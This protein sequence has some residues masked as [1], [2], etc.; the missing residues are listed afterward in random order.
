MLTVGAIFA[1]RYPAVQ[2]YVTKKAAAYLSKQL[3]TEIR[4]EKVYLKP[5]R[6]LQIEG[7]SINDRAGKKILDAKNVTATFSLAKLFQREI[8]IRKLA[9]EDTYVNYELYT[10]STNISF[11]IDY[12]TPP[13]DT[14]SSS[15][16]SIRFNLKQVVLKNNQFKLVDHR[17]ESHQEGLNFNDLDLYAIS[18]EFD[19]ITISDKEVKVNISKLTFQ[20]K[21]GLHLRELSAKSYVS[22]TR[23]EFQDLHLRTNRSKVG[24]YLQFSYRSFADFEDFIDKVEMKGQLLDAF[25]DSRDIQYF[26]PEMERVKFIT[27]ISKA[28]VSGRVANLHAHNVSLRTG[29]HTQ[30]SG[31]LSMRGLPDIQ[32]TTFDFDLASLRTSAKDLEELVPALANLHHFSLP[33]QLHKL[34]EISYKGSFKGFYYNFNIH[35]NAATALGE[36]ATTSNVVIS[37]SLR[38]SGLLNSKSFELGK[39]LNSQAI[40]QTAFD[41]KY[42]GKGINL[43]SL[44]LAAEGQISNLSFKDYRYARA[45]FSGNIENRLLSVSGSIDDP[46]AMLSLQGNIDWNQTL[47]IYTLSSTIETL[48][49]KRLNVFSKD[50]IVVKQ[51]NLQATLQGS[52]LNSLNGH[53]Y[54][55]EI[56]FQ[57]SR[58]TFAMNYLDFTSEGDELSKL[59]ILKS[60]VV[61]GQLSG[62]IDLN[63]IGSY[64]R[65]LAMR[66]APAINIEAS[67]YN[68]QN[69][70]LQ[71]NIKSFDPISAL[72]D[73]NLQ[74]EDGAHLTAKF[75][76]DDY[77]ANFKAFSPTVSYRGMKIN[78]LSLTERADDRAFSL[79]VDADRFSF[80]DSAYVE[81][82]HIQNTLANDSLTFQIALSESSRANY[83]NLNGNIHF[84]YNKPAY[85]RFDKSE[86]VLDKEKWQINEDADLRVSKGKF[87]LKNLL[88]KRDRQEVSLN[89]VLSNEDDDLE[90]AF[91]DFSLSSL[92]GITK[93]LG[94]QLQGNLNGDVHVHSVFQKPT[95]STHIS[96]TPI[97]FNNLPIGT[98]QVNADFDP[99]HGLVQL[100]SKLVD[101]DGRG[102]DLT[103]T[104]DVQSSTDALQL[105]GKVKDLDLGILQPFVRTLVSDLYG[106]V[107]G[108]VNIRGTLRNPI[109]NG[110][111]DIRDA[112][113]LVNYLNTTYVLSN[114]QSLIQDNRIHLNNL[115]FSDARNSKASAKGFIDLSTL[116]DPTLDIEATAD[117]FQIL[118]TGRKDN[119]MFFGTAY[120]SGIFRFKGPTSGIN[121]DINARSNPNTVVTIPFNSSLKVS[122]NDFFYFTNTDS[123]A[124][125]TALSKR[126]FQGLTMNMDLNLTRDAEINLENNIGSLKGVGTGNISLRI[127]NL[128]DFEMFGDYHVLAGKFHFTAQ[129]FF[130]KFFDLKEGGT[131]RW[132]G[133]PAEATI[134]LS[135]SYQ[136]RTSVAP[137]YNAAGRTENNDRILAQADMILKGTLSQPEVS[138][139]LNFPQDP[140]VKDELQ[141][142]LS[143]GNNINQ[144]AISLIVRRSFT[145]ASTQEFGREVNNTL[146]S[147]GTEIAF[148]QLNSIIS[149]SL[150]MNFLD[151]NI[152]SFNDASASL[153]FF[154]DRLILTGGVSDRSRSQLT[155]L[156]LFSD[157]VAT[158]AEVTFRL[159]QDGNLVLRAYNRLN[160]RNF[161]FTPYSDYISAVGLV[162]RQEFN[163]LS[164]FWRKLWIWNERKLRATPTAAVD[165]LSNN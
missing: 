136:Q 79:L 156:T 47:P 163:S 93:P 127:S 2:T 103:G 30:L 15:P 48:D 85:I 38:Y 82:I 118:N 51:S 80:T 83:L 58:G 27:A 87:Y 61:D 131:I 76:S 146:L 43:A 140:Y 77:T 31:D 37:P 4:I 100:H 40:R 22:T 113:F 63:T 90:I 24:N 159:R 162:Y 67:P 130:N 91:R 111:A 56:Q 78:N 45:N 110:A 60:D 33:E 26:A 115:R 70:D 84:A 41:I 97:I 34:G 107:S 71:V 116:T 64:F 132:A 161:L 75:S 151:L 92:S 125:D 105:Q 86:I 142:Y 104:Y 19:D 59:L 139:D 28:E 134:N 160:T 145:P 68:P 158:D 62:Q 5:F 6:S 106:K 8:E 152:R 12:L 112:S 89:G 14:T 66:Y 29:T 65:S 148:N 96:T 9:L 73:P 165:S 102:V 10:D 23:M 147:A 69:F 36:L 17:R 133:N 25:V 164:E 1:L 141:G 16:A 98:L 108:D 114:Q 35:G 53:I 94:I 3:E 123:T 72:F 119:E 154:D 46:H 21:S 81:H 117:N 143:D 144:Q 137:L 95:L 99:A 74:L 50:S 138:F 44:Q 109:I 88:L 150:N 57:T 124:K 7:V 126:L 155:D 20:E 52:S 149:Q 157:Q 135:A 129:D 49:L 128:G 18:G 121:I 101:I 39:L 55:D 54:A 122:D 153:R 120:A 13:K 11:L 32:H 42:N